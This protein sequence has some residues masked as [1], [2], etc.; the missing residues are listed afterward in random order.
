[1]PPRMQGRNAH[2]CHHPFS[3]A[4]GELHGHKTHGTSP[5][6]ETAWGRHPVGVALRRDAPLQP[7]GKAGRQVRK[8]SS[9][10]KC[11]AAA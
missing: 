8:G 6:S 10:S 2:H 7:F 1:M 5:C 4:G 3:S 9:V 11:S